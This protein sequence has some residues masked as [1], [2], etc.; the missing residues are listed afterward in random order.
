MRVRVRVFM[1]MSFQNFRHRIG[2][3]RFSKRF[4]SGMSRMPC[5]C[6]RH[7]GTRSEFCMNSVWISRQVAAVSTVSDAADMFQARH[8][9]DLL[10]IVLLPDT[11]RFGAGG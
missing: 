5:R 7:S 6:L 8:C 9:R 2:V 10:V 1:V 11:Q 4:L 3:S